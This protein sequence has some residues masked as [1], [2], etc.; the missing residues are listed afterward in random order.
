MIRSLYS[1]LDVEQ[2]LRD[3]QALAQ[4][5]A[6]LA[7]A[8]AYHDGLFLRLSTSSARPRIE[9][10][11]ALWFGARY[12]QGQIFLE[13]LPN[14]QR[15]FPVSFEVT[16]ESE[17]ASPAFIPSFQ[18]VTSLSPSLPANIWP[19]PLPLGTPPL[20]AFYS[21]KGG[22]GRTTHLMGLTRAASEKSKPIRLL[23]IDADLEAPGITSLLRAEKDFGLPTFSLIDFLALAHTEP[24]YDA[25]AAINLAADRIAGQTLRVHTPQGS[26]EHLVLPAFRD[27]A[28]SIHLD[29]RPEHL[30]QVP[31]DAWRLVML[32]GLLG[33]KLAVDGILIDL[34]AGLSELAGPI[35]FDPRV[36]RVLV[37]TPSVQ[38]VDGTVLI[39]QQLRKVAPPLERDDLTDPTVVLSFVTPEMATSPQLQ[40]IKTRLLDAYAY[41]DRQDE[42]LASVSSRLA[43]EETTFAQQMLVV[44]SF[45]DAMDRLEGT[46]IARQ[47]GALI[48]EWLPSPQP[49]P[50]TSTVP[51]QKEPE[52]LKAR[53]QALA[54]H[55]K[56]FEYAESGQGESFLTTSPLRALAQRFHTSPPLAVI[57][58]AKGAGKTFTYLQLVRQTLWTRFVSETLSRPVEPQWGLIWPLLRPKKLEPLALDLVQTTQQHLQI[59]L[60]LDSPPWPLSELQDALSELLSQRDLDEAGWRRAWFHLFARALGLKLRPEEDA[61]IAL[62]HFLQEKQQRVVIL[63]DGLEDLFPQLVENPQQQVAL[64]ALLQDV[65]DRLKEI[66][67]SPLGLLVFVRA[68]FARI[69]IAQNI[70]QFERLYEPFALRWNREEALKLTVWICQQARVLPSENVQA[71]ILSAE[72]SRL[73]LEYIWGRKLGLEGSREPLSAEYVLAALSDFKGRIQARDLVRLLHYAASKSLQAQIEDRLLHPRS[74]RDAVKPCSEQKLR[75]IEEEMPQ[76]EAIFKKLRTSAD[77][78]LPFDAAEF[79]LDRR[80]IQLLEDTGVIL[81]DTDGYYMPEIFR[82]GLGFELNRGARPRVIALAKRAAKQQ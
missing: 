77:R 33:S 22:V 7:G 56:R 44:H 78:K 29:I 75:E 62:S 70:G 16:G 68:D 34:R 40:Q 14:Q 63:I 81:E 47:M 41:K 13:A 21:F 38:S 64:R 42:Q 11:L 30:V 32:L 15:L 17:P 73:V 61:S 71:E 51:P 45:K 36:H 1:W 55:A 66:P 9:Q 59:T 28:Q 12:Q 60:G 19:P 48:G 20:M 80:E 82:L 8:S 67:N 37:T 6:G 76:L 54:D 35:L 24:E 4:W 46:P 79:E 53:R 72:Q 43:I 57:I 69:S 49:V 52:D 31:S 5:P 50:T 27:D 25:P 39:L 74:I 10:E 23:L 2:V 18:R 65:P 58:G 3:R 26:V